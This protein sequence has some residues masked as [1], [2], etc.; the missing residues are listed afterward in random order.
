MFKIISFSGSFVFLRHWNSENNFYLFT[1]TYI[2]IYAWFWNTF[3]QLIIL[4]LILLV[5]KLISLY[6]QYRARLACISVY[7]WLTN[8]QVFILISQTLIMDNYKNGRTFQQFKGLIN[9]PSPHP[10]KFSTDVISGIMV[11]AQSSVLT[12]YT[13]VERQIN[14][15]QL[16]ILI[17]E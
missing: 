15:P 5:L 10:G 14:P 8:F 13:W 1:N 11:V 4:T 7:C 6:H 3:S 16:N 2:C 12:H 9:P 17:H